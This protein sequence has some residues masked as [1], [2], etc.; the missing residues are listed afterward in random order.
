[1]YENKDRM[2]EV[3]I[4]YCGM[5]VCFDWKEFTIV[6]GLK[7]YPP[8]PSQVIP[9][10]TQKKA[11]HIPKKGKG[12]SS[13]RKDLVP[14]IGPSF[15]NKNLIEALKGVLKDKGLSKKHK[16]SLLLVWFVYNILYARDV[17]NNISPG[18]INLSE[19]L[20]ASNSYLWGCESF[21]MTVQYLLTLLTPKTVNLY[22]FSWAFMEEVSCLRILR[23]LLA[24][25]DKNA[26]FV[27][28][29]NT[30]EEAIVH[31]WLIST[32]RDLKMPFFLNLQFLQTLSDPK[33][34]DGIKIEL[35][36]A[37]AIRRKIILEC[38]LVDVND[39][40]G[41]GAVVGD[42]DAPLTV[43]ETKSHYDYNHT[44]CTGFSLDFATPSECSACKCQDCK[45]KY[46]GV[47][48]V[49]NALT[50]SV[51]EMASKRGVIPSKRILYPYTPLEIKEA[52]RR[53]KD[54]SKASSSIHKSKITMPLS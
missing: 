26:K 10:L 21:K 47:I 14:I 49:I 51:K 7:C 23:W 42:N 53:R 3:W 19:D 32:N 4:N 35:F 17:N 30:L 13:N 52:K 31:P 48:N 28:L 43:F 2:D 27:D 22:G 54:T 25:T 33:V 16:Q 9:T 34:I 6:T 45:A 39:G 1:M 12:K 50:T 8:S 11:P 38:G 46:D 18:L 44:G 41:S 29:F 37:T 24:K 40:S 5:P 20:E 36:G 15:K